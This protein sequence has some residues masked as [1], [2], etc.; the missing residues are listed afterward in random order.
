M[1]WVWVGWDG[2][3]C[4]G[5][6]Y[7]HLFPVLILY[8]SY[9]TR[10]KVRW[11]IHVKW[12]E[13]DVTFHLL[14]QPNISLRL[15]RQT[16]PAWLHTWYLSFPFLRVIHRTPWLPY[17]SLDGNLLCKKENDEENSGTFLAHSV[18]VSPQIL[19]V[20]N[21]I[22]D[23]CDKYYL[24]HLWQIPGIHTCPYLASQS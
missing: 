19:F 16:A 11:T 6:F 21:T 3:L 2:N 15:A 24:W 1:G 5:W 14:L 17:A 13:A 20:I 9:K 10:S 12:Q 23:I 7:E 4:V 8:S 22:C 18:L